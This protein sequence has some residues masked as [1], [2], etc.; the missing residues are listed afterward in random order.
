MRKSITILILLSFANW[1]IA[2]TISYESIKH[3][4]INI[5]EV[6][7]GNENFEDFSNLKLLLENVEIVMLGEQSHGEGTAYDTKIK[8]I[9]YLHQELGFDMLAFES[10]IFDCG[11]GVM[12]LPVCCLF[13]DMLL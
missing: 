1:S 11:G 13:R 4:V 8:L 9:K 5:G 6:H 12:L 7:N 10:G 3:A 2:Q